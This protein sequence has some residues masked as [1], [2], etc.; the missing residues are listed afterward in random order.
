MISNTAIAFGDIPPQ[1]LM[2]F[3]YIFYNLRAFGNE[4]PQVPPQKLVDWED[5][6]DQSR[7]V[8]G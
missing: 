8:G 2:T 1:L 4:V 5:V 3:H 7:N 6:V